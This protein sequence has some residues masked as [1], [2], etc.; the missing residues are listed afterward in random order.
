[1]GTRDEYSRGDKWLLII[2]LVVGLS[3]GVH[4]MALLTIPAIGFYTILKNYKVVTVKNFII[5]NV[6]V[7]SYY[8]LFSNYYCL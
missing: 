2:S 5:A 4:F 8:Y 7:V 3:F 1:M 6:V